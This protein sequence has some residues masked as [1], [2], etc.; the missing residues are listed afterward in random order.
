MPAKPLNIL[1]A[2][3]SVSIRE[4]YCDIFAQFG[5]NVRSVE[6]GF[7]ALLEIREEIPDVLL[8][9]L[10][11]PGMSGFELLGVV[12]HLFPEIVVIAMSGSF[13]GASVPEGVIADAFYEKGTSLSYLL[14]ILESTTR[15]DRQIDLSHNQSARFD[16]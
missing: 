2:D 7:S 9:D 14:R 16:A 3:D 8:S 6:E 10:H 15:F 13:C 12:R 1:I 4:A 11:M 5:Y